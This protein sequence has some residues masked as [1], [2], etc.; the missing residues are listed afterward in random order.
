M[1]SE[2]AR[3]SPLGSPSGKPHYIESEAR[4]CPPTSSPRTR[5]IDSEQPKRQTERQ[6]FHSQPEFHANQGASLLIAV[7]MSVVRF[8]FC[9]HKSPVSLGREQRAESREIGRRRAEESR[10]DRAI[11]VDETVSWK[12]MSDLA[13]EIMGT[14]ARRVCLNCVAAT[15]SSNKSQG[16]DLNWH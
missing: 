3:Q 6:C 8:V 12:L 14:S 5:S 15:Q 7:A 2:P 9:A 11:S 4:L 10:S 16:I 1:L 13:G